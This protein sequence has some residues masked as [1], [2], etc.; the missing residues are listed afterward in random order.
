MP[1]TD[2][3]VR[4]AKPAAKQYK[5]ADG[6]GLFLLVTTSG[7]KLWRYKYR[8]LGREHLYAIG[9]YPDIS[10]TAARAALAEARERVKRGEHPIQ[11]KRRRKAVARMAAEN[12]FETVARV[13]HASRIAAGR[14]TAGHASKVL[15]DL[16]RD[17][18]PTLGRRPLPDIT[19]ADILD[20]LKVIEKRGAPTVAINVRQHCSAVFLEGIRNGACTDDPASALRGVVLRPEIEHARALGLAGARGLLRKI[21]GYGGNLT[22]KVGLLLLV[23]TFVRTKEMRYAEWSEFDLDAGTWLIPKEKMKKRRPHLVPLSRQAIE[24][25]RML[26]PLTG[27]GRYLFPNT[28][29]VDKV[30]SATTINRALEYMGFDTA[31]VTGH[32]FRAT[33]STILYEARYR[34]EV[35]EMQLAHVEQKKTKRSYNHAKYLDERA[36]MMQW[37]ADEIDASGADAAPPVTELSAA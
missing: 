27:A 26:M 10:I 4:Q 32:D 15:G 18:F 22:T 17:V 23:Y 31:P 28:R 8:L 5:M 25:V 20:V 29:S 19:A 11:E 14:W 3:R 1:L 35:V 24:A 16:E 6:Q 30:M 36:A 13:W 37:F 33:A 34:E 21:R 12:S 2:V 7:S 9:P